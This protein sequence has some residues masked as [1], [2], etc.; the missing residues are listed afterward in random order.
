MSD[1]FFTDGLSIWDSEDD[2][3]RI[4]GKTGCD[5]LNQM[6]KKIK[7][8]EKDIDLIDELTNNNCF[9]S[10]SQ[11]DKEI[12]KLKAQ[13]KAVYVYFYHRPNGDSEAYDKLWNEIIEDYE[14]YL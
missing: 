2:N 5:K 3:R 8:F 1:R 13:L 4:G 10:L 9:L 12:E 6:D 11:R 14:K 7:D